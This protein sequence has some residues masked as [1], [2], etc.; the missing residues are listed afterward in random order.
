VEREKVK[1]RKKR[2]CSEV[3]LN[4]PGESVEAVLKK[5]RKAMVGRTL[6]LY[7]FAVDKVMIKESYYYYY[8]Y[9]YY[10]LQVSSVHFSSCDVNKP[11]E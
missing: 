5:K 9:Y 4:S 6:C 3:S 1:S 10:L 7:S 11:S 8:Y 2:T